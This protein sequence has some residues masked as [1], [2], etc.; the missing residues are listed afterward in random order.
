MRIGVITNPNSRKNKGR[1]N[2]VAE[3]Q[4]IVGDAG[5]VH[6]TDSVESI[7]PILRDFLRQRAQY[8]VADGGDGALHW[9]IRCGLE[10]LEES[11]FA[12]VRLP[13][14]VPANGGTIDYV[15]SNVGITGKAE[16]IL[17][18]L[19]DAVVN[20]HTIEEVE[21][22]SMRIE[23][24]EVTE[25]G[26]ETFRTYGFGAAVGGVGQRFYAKYYAHKDPNPRTI[27]KVVGTALASLPIAMSPLRA[28]PGIPE[29]LRT[30]ARDLFRPTA[31]KVS[32]DGEELPYREY[33][34]IN[35]SAMSLA[36]HGVLKLFPRA[37]EPG[38]L[39]ALVG[40]PSPLGIVRNLPNLHLGRELRGAK[41][42]DKLCQSM[43]VEATGD[44]LL[45]PII[46]GEYYRNLRCIRFELG[47]RLRIPKVIGQ[48]RMRRAA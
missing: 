42:V 22:D 14:A 1:T 39:Q 36:Y 34:G 41:I 12:G 5:Q 35:L 15:A 37:D 10:V 11:E 45:A 13:L 24:T 9:M 46:D 26:L 48:G 44:E 25:R 38:R 19:R 43:L 30:Y 6:A 31:C 8:W 3:L 47:P 18:T 33:S 20:G 23:A 4:R 16:D 7:K 40:S 28:L 17:A 32:I 29:E 2:R 21:V 27:M